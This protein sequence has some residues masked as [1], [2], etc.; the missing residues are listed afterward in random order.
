MGLL[1]QKWGYYIRN[2]AIISGMGLLCQNG[3]ILLI[4]GVIPL[5]YGAI[6]LIFIK[7]VNGIAPSE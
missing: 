2:G 5:I 1:Y 3:V 7:K 6:P 4:L